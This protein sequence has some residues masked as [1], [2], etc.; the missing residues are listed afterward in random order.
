MLGVFFQALFYFSE[1]WF[2]HLNNDQK[3]HTPP[4]HPGAALG[5]YL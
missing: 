5:M 2:P 3:S 4:P 1:P